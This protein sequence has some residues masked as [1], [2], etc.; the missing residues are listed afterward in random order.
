MKLLKDRPKIGELI[1][2]PAGTVGIG[3]PSLFYET[4]VLL[5][6]D[7]IGLVLEAHV[8]GDVWFDTYTER[9]RLW[10]RT[11]VTDYTALSQEL[12]THTPNRSKQ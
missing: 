8:R 11:A 12:S 5:R 2:L 6:K 3:N 10:F 4:V 7:T 9:G 1:F